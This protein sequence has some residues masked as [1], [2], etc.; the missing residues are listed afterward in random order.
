MIYSHMRHLGEKIRST[1]SGN[2]ITTTTTPQLPTMAPSGKQY[3]C[4]QVEGE[5]S[6]AAKCSKSIALIKFLKK[7]FEVESIEQQFI[8]I[9]GLW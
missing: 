2:T 3:L 9:K 7:I 1:S 6:H 4:F 5:S 8:I